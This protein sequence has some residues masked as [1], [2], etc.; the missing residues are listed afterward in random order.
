MRLARALATSTAVAAAVLTAVS[1][2]PL[3]GPAAAAPDGRSRYTFAVIGDVPYGADQI[4][5]FPGWIQQI[6]ADPAVRSV[7]H[8]G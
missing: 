8:L 1:V 2:A 5:A 7:V 3:Q 4:A 6:N